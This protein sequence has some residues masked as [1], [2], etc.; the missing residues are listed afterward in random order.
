MTGANRGIGQALVEEVLRR[1]AKRVYAGT[2]R[3]LTHPDERVTPLT[4]DV[5]D[6]AQ[7]QAA[8][9]SVASLDVLINNAGVALYADLGDRAALE[10]HLAVNLFGSYD[11]TQAFLP[12]LTRSRGTIV[13]VLSLAALAPVPL[14]PT[15][16]MSKAAAFSLTQSLRAAL[17]GQGVAVHAVLPGPVDTDMGPKGDIPKA[18]VESVARAILDGVENGDEEIFPDPLS[19]SM[20]EGWRNGASKALERQMAAFVQAEP[21]NS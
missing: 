7:I 16:A 2:R 12:L 9:E 20:A 18:S 5:T 17:A 13:N 4:L 21:V 14:D 6:A 10:Q 8:V 1:G 15:Y 11:T 19:E 3:P